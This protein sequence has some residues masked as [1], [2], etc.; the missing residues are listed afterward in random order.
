MQSLVQA[1]PLTA[2]FD[3]GDYNLHPY[4]KSDTL[5]DEL[6]KSFYFSGIL[7][8][9]ILLEK[10]ETTYDIVSGRKRLYFAEKYLKENSCFCRILPAN[11]S[12]EGILSLLLEDQFLDG[13]LSFFEQAHFCA[14]TEKLL[15]HERRI[16]K[17]F[18]SLP[19]GRITKGRQYLLQSDRYSDTVKK[20]VHH[21]LVSEKAL[22]TLCKFQKN[23]QEMLMQ[24][25]AAI[26]PGQNKQKRLLQEI[27]ETLQRNEISFIAFLSSPQIAEIVNHPEMNPPQ[28]CEQLLTYC[29]QKNFPMLHAAAASFAKKV[30]NLN[31]PSNC[32]VE[33]SQAFE[34]DEVSLRITFPNLEELQKK[35]QKISQEIS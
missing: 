31:L 24:L 23:D 21:G 16:Q 34:R 13:K 19:P 27:F 35:W 25:F 28:K 15:G 26:L 18:Q 3:S 33:H 14:L 10:E 20:S 6:L 29:Y 17:F 1:I 22:T 11:Y 2:I 30:D 9:P 7:H 4:L 32:K 8:P 5:S 12:D